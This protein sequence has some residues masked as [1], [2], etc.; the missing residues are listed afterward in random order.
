[1]LSQKTRSWVKRLKRRQVCVW[2]RHPLSWK[3]RH[4]GDLA[5]RY[6]LGPSVALPQAVAV[7]SA[8]NQPS[9]QHAQATL[10]Q[11]MDCNFMTIDLDAGAE[12][13]SIILGLEHNGKKP[14][15]HP[16]M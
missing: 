7:P 11:H 9:S 14:V 6:I 15:G 8:K 16:D 1:V 3:R 4:F 10:A 2:S 5:S 13:L 12:E